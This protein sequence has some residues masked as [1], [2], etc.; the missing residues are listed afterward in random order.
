MYFGEFPQI[1]SAVARTKQNGG[2]TNGGCGQAARR[3]G[4]GAARAG[5]E[6]G[7]RAGADRGRVRRVQRPPGRAQRAARGRRRPAGRARK[8]PPLRRARRLQAGARAGGVRRRPGRT[9]LSGR[10][11]VDR[12]LH[13]RAAAIGRGA[14]LRRRRRF[15]SARAA[16]ARRPPA[17]SAWSARTP[18]N[19]GR[20]CSRGG[21]RSA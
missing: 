6:P 12:R 3:R 1:P 5:A 19:F 14:G 7:A 11:R 17:S 2:R 10:R 16:A 21:P 18:A 4:A 15:G 20:R 9:G 13:G 8:R